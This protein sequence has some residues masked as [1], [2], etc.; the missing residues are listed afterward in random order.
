MTDMHM[1]SDRM[2][3]NCQWHQFYVIPRLH[4]RANIE[5]TSSKRRA[6]IQQAS[7]NIEQIWSMHKA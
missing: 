2:T 1:Y 5:Q 4:D 3:E 6:D 7:S